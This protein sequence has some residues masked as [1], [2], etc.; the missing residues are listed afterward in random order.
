MR[1]VSLPLLK[2]ISKSWIVSWRVETSASTSTVQVM[3][4]TGLSYS[5]SLTDD[6]VNVVSG[7]TG[8][9]GT[10]GEVSRTFLVPGAASSI[11]FRV[12]EE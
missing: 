9:A 3:P 11:F 2:L 4:L 12:E 6:F 10:G 7:E 1:T 8:I 5:T